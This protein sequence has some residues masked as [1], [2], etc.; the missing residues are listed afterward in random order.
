MKWD[1]PLPNL[2]V[3]I[4]DNIFSCLFVKMVYRKGSKAILIKRLITKI[5]GRNL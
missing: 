3:S 4:L 2:Q 1:D 5:L